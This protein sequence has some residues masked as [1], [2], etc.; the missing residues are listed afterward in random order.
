MYHT[1]KLTIKLKC[2]HFNCLSQTPTEPSSARAG[3]SEKYGYQ[4]ASIPSVPPR[5]RAPSPM[6]HSLEESQIAQLWSVDKDATSFDLTALEVRAAEITAKTTR[7]KEKLAANEAIR[8]SIRNWDRAEQKA[9]EVAIYDYIRFRAKTDPLL[10]HIDKTGHIYCY[11]CVEYFTKILSHDSIK[12]R[13]RIYPVSFNANDYRHLWLV[14]VVADKDNSAAFQLNPYLEQA[15]IDV[16]SLSCFWDVRHTYSSEYNRISTVSISDPNNRGTQITLQET[17]ENL[18]STLFIETAI[19]QGLQTLLKLEK[20]NFLLGEYIQQFLDQNIQLIGQRMEVVFNE[21]SAELSRSKRTFEDAM[22]H[23]ISQTALIRTRETLLAPSIFTQIL[24]KA[25]PLANV[26]N[27]PDTIEAA[28]I[29]WQNEDAACIRSSDRISPDSIEHVEPVS[30]SALHE[31]DGSPHSSAASSVTIS[32][33]QPRIT[34][35][36]VGFDMHRLIR[37]I[38]DPIQKIAVRDELQAIL[39]EYHNLKWH[40]RDACAWASALVRSVREICSEANPLLPQYNI[41]PL[42]QSARHSDWRKR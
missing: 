11:A 40:K 21:K 14:L 33:A 19:G 20:N 15:K 7:R 22:T 10:Y 28:I 1:I 17:L 39:N 12:Q 4:Y 6:R 38:Q 8:D 37:E 42:M 5:P 26:A 25:Q 41:D 34:A 3:V 30:R 9:L 16:E 18:K 2:A 23:L 31:S 36:Q 32:R 29:F 24:Q 27:G 35:Y 13:D